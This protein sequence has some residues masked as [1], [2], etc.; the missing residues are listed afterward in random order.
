[1]GGAITGVRKLGNVLKQLGAG[2]LKGAIKGM[3]KLGGAIKNGLNHKHVSKFGKTF[4]T[5]LKA[6]IGVR[7]LYALVRKLTAAVKEGIN[8]VAQWNGGNNK[9]NESLSML[10]SSLTQFK[11]AIG[12]A[13]SPII[14]IVAPVLNT[15]INLLTKAA[16]AVGQFFA[17]LGGSNTA[18]RAT[19]VNQT[20]IKR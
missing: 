7:G 16:T 20:K 19:K 3:Q 15:L 8:N 11:N 6:A 2:A 17:K 4:S 18:L 1:M 5:V 10:M 9:V 14:P 12:A 13:F